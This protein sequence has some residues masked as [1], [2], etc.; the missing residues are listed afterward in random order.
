MPHLED[1][2]LGGDPFCDAYFEDSGDEEIP[3]GQR[4]NLAAMF[5]LAGTLEI[6]VPAQVGELRAPPAPPLPPAAQTAPVAGPAPA[7]DLVMLVAALQE[8]VPPPQPQAEVAQSL[9]AISQTLSALSNKMDTCQILGRVQAGLRRPPLS[10]PI[11]R[12]MSRPPDPR[13][14]YSPLE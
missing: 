12:R 5:D 3:C 13:L 2:P 1:D 8:A 10:S 7:I 14:G 4:D 6:P 11:S 9:V